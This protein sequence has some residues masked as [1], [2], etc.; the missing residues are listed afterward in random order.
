MVE[1]KRQPERKWS[2]IL[3]NATQMDRKCFLILRNQKPYFVIAKVSSNVL[4]VLIFQLFALSFM[5]HGLRRF[6]AKI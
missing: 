2:E 5:T 6:K 4:N 3:Q 1:G